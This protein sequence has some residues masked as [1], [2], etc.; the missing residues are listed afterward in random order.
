MSFISNMR[1]G[2]LGLASFCLALSMAAA[3][4]AAAQQVPTPK[5]SQAPAGTPYGAA[6][7]DLS[8]HGYV[9]E[10]VFIEGTSRS[11][12][13]APGL[14]SVRDG[15]WNATPTGPAAPYKVRLLIER[16]SD[17]AKFNGTVVVE[18]LNVSAMR[19]AGTFDGFGEE[20]MRAGYAYVG[21]SAQGAGVKHLRET[22]DT[23]RYGSLAHP[24]DSYS[25]DIFSQAAKALR[26]GNPAPLGN[27]TGRIKSLVA[28]G[29]SQSGSRLF[30]YF[31]SAHQTARVIDGFIPFITA[32]GAMLTQDPLPVV[33]MPSGAGAVIR[34]DLRTPVLFENSESELPGAARGVHSQPDSTWFRM[35]EYAGT[36]HA[37]RPPPPPGAAAAAALNPGTAGAAGVQCYVPP[38]NSL[39]VQPIWRAMVNAMD[40][41]LRTGRAPASAPRVAMS[42]PADPAQPATIVRA[43]AT[44]LANG[45]IRLPDVAVPTRTLWGTPPEAVLKA[46]PN[47]RLFGAFDNWNGD[48]DA[49]DAD[50]ALD[51]SPKP[52]PSLVKLYGDNAKYV[53]AVKRTTDGLVARGYL[54]APDA[55][56]MVEAAKKVAIR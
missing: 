34:T 23:A 51:I 2:S 8:R 43:P 12:V 13:A 20:F 4:P 1:R 6:G 47:C 27:L 29:G 35:W 46:N 21:V 3:S 39:A 56:A 42:I 10:E 41:W 44:R 32:G 40:Q 15:R 48:S 55:N 31:N 22:A 24:G 7:Q 26:S 17:P 49:W 33:R 36:S 5:V 52:E 11:F 37:Q 28:W 38:A 9:Q 53:A 16:P 50:P 18:W 25:Y 14:E 19:D 54:L 45:G 30:T